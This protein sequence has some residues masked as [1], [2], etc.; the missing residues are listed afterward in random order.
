MESGARIFNAKDSRWESDVDP[1]P[2]QSVA[3][4]SMPITMIGRFGWGLADQVLSSATNF[5]LGLVVA[6]SV[7]MRELGAFGVAYA[8]FSLSLGAI[9]AIAGELLVV[10]HSV[11]SPDQWRNG[12]KG[13]AGTAVGAG[14]IA[15]VACLLAGAKSGGS[16]QLVL[17]IVGVF[18]PGLLLQDV[19]R[20][21]FFAQGRGSAAF[22]NDAVWA[23]A[24]FAGFG[25]LKLMGILSVAWF[26]VAWAAAGSFAAL[27]GLLQL[28]V[29]PSGPRAAVAWLRQ[30]QD[31]AP[32]FLTEF[33]VSSG[34]SN[35]TFFAIGGI[36]G[37]TELGRLRAGEIAVGPLNV[38]FGGIGLVA[39]PEGVRLLRESTTRLVQGCRWVSTALV[40]G[41]LAWAGVVLVLLPSAGRML[42]AT[43]W[44]AARS[45]L[46]PL[47]I[48]ATGFASAYGA[49]DRTAC[50]RGSEA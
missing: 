32:R 47:L 42:L 41:V 18:L 9:R 34:I 48:G 15:G 49:L 3:A 19:W 39:T 20:F 25:V 45:L 17:G 2:A 23:V 27:L 6:R 5:L 30:H 16:L 38:L 4:R 14:V 44:D 22:L 29:R 28:G 33:A 50:A 7:G 12:V 37:L 36:A 26:T 21:A 31:L 11:A 35:L 1:L 8:T 46:P 40:A 43:N 10:R 24:M 13:A